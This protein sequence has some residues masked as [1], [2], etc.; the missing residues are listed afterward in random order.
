VIG[1]RVVPF[2]VAKAGKV[3]LRIQSSGV[4]PFLLKSMRLRRAP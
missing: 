2:V 3:E 1:R 4:A